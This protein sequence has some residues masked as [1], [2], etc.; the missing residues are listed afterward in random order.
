[1][2]PGITTSSVKFFANPNQG[3]QIGFAY[4]ALV[5]FGSENPDSYIYQKRGSAGYSIPFTQVFLRPKLTQNDLHFSSIGSGSAASNRRALPNSYTM[6]VRWRTS[7][8][9]GTG[10]KNEMNTY[11]QAITQVG[12]TVFTGGDFKYVESAGGERV[13]QSFL[14]G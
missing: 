5:N 2:A 7:E 10:K 9:T 14:A 8:Q 1:M 12:D 6:P 3:Y 4:G 13:N 11:V